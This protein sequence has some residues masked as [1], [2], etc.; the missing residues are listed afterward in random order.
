MFNYDLDEIR[1][2]LAFESEVLAFEE[3][4]INFEKLCDMAKS[5]IAI[6]NKITDMISSGVGKAKKFINTMFGWVNS[7]LSKFTKIGKEMQKDTVKAKN[8]IV[9]KLKA[10]TVAKESLEV[11][12]ESG[13][14]SD[15]VESVNAFI[16]YA[17][18]IS[19]IAAGADLERKFYREGSA[20]KRLFFDNALFMILALPVEIILCLMF[21]SVGAVLSWFT[22]AAI[23]Y[24]IVFGRQAESKNY[25]V[26]AFNGFAY[27]YLQDMITPLAMKKVKKM[28]TKHLY[29]VTTR[30]VFT[31]SVKEHIQTQLTEA[32]NRR[33]WVTSGDLNYSTELADADYKKF[34]AAK[35]TSKVKENIEKL[36]DESMQNVND[37]TFLRMDKADYTRTKTKEYGEL[38]G[39]LR[40]FIKGVAK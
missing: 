37:I 8:K 20:T 11:G 4:Y 21:G 19:I 29:K 16:S 30:R 7:I 34:D 35:M 40:D 9:K 12:I 10:A 33:D 13:D 28:V 6:E 26:E 3:D 27:T 23:F 17:A 31:S 32:L 36:K 1:S 24:N 22:D 14:I 39:Q 5:D 25:G 2:E 18:G 15:V 38:I